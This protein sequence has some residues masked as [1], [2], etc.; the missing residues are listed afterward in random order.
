MKPL[1]IVVLFGRESRGL[2]NDEISL[3]DII[4]RIPTGNDDPTLN[5]SHACGIILYEIFRKINKLTIGRGKKPVLVASRENRQS[6]Y[7]LIKI[8][9]E[10][11]KIGKHRKENVYLAFRNIL[12]RSFMSQKEL[13]LVSG[14]FSKISRFID[15]LQLFEE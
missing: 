15:G 13:S 6:L 12:E 14:I 1:K 10:K 5:L 9:L 11:L 8:L 7:E 3:A 4:L 2:T